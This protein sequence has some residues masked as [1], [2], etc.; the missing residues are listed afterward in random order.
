MKDMNSGKAAQGTVHKGTGVVKKVD[1][2]KAAVTLDHEAIKSLNWPA[3][4]MS[5]NVKERKM[6]EPLKP[7]QKVQFEFVQQ[8]KENVITSIK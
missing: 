3:M 6:I 7:G 8:G 5:F 4:A 1:T 2:E